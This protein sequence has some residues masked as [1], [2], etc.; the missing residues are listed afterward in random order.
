MKK[1]FVSLCVVTAAA[2]SHQ[3]DPNEPSNEYSEPKDPNVEYRDPDTNPLG[4]ANA[5]EASS[6]AGG[7]S[8][9]SSAR[10]TSS[11]NYSQPMTGGSPAT[12]SSAPSASTS[13]P[14]VSAPASETPDNTGVNKRDQ[15][16]ATLTPMD[17]GNNQA[18]LNITQAIRKA[19]VGS[20]GLSFNAKNVKIIT[21]AGKVTLRGPVKDASERTRIVALARQTAGVQNVDD[22]LE[23]KP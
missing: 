21:S 2:C 6:F 9:S 8:Y 23:I 22:Q 20:D 11:P 12:T 3:P 18:D 4:H 7:P 10:A 14:M 13:A 15:D 1:T 19:V 16:N 17:Q 5:V